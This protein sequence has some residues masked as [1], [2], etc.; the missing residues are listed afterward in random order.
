VDTREQRLLALL[1]EA[2][3]DSGL[4]NYDFNVYGVEKFLH[5]VRLEIDPSYQGSSRERDYHL[6]WEK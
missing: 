4:W 3:A 6:Y 5:R 1:V 2:E